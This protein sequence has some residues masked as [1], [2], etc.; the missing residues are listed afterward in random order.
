MTPGLPDL[1]DA[2]TAGLLDGDG[3]IS[4]RPVRG[5]S[6][7]ICFAI[8]VQVSQS[9]RGAE[10]LAFLKRRWGGGVY[11][12]THD[13]PNAADQLVWQLEGGGARALLI[14]VTPM[15]RLKRAQAELAL[16][17]LSLSPG[18]GGSSP[19]WVGPR[20]DRALEI[21]DDLHRLNERGRAGSPRLCDL[22]PGLVGG[23]PST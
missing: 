7:Q 15:L 4:A 1:E 3:S 5:K 20:A 17:L 12:Q 11:G 10:C 18:N 22:Q 23:K 19:G 6:R 9:A 21:V 2:Y 14:R 13:N 8:R 16:E